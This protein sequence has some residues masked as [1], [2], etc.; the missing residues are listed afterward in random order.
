MQP[1][2]LRIGV[3]GGRN[4]RNKKKVWQVMNQAKG[5][6]GDRMFVVVGCAPGLDRYVRWWCDENLKPEQY[7]VFYADWDELGNYAGHERN[8]RMALFGLDMLI[9]F[10][11][12]VGTANMKEQTEGLNTALHKTQIM[13][14]SE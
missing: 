11:G 1:S 4:Y 7:R 2:Q 6:L 3:T 8:T 13:E 10:P 5:T 9:V 14:I 12:G